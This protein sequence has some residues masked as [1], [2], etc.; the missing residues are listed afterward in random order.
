[1]KEF[2]D[3]ISDA[4][5]G[6]DDIIFE[7][8]ERN[9]FKLSFLEYK[10]GDRATYYPWEYIPKFGYHLERRKLN[11]NQLQRYLE[12]KSEINSLFPSLIKKLYYD[13]N[14]QYHILG[15]DWIIKFQ[16]GD[17]DKALSQLVKKQLITNAQK[18]RIIQGLV[19]FNSLVGLAQ[20]G[21]T[22][23][24][25][26]NTKKIRLESSSTI[27][28]KGK[29]ITFSYE[30]FLP[31]FEIKGESLDISIQ[32]FKKPTNPIHNQLNSLIKKESF[33]RDDSEDKILILYSKIKREFLDDLLK[34]KLMDHLQILFEGKFF[35]CL[36][37][38]SSSDLVNSI[39]NLRRQPINQRGI[40]WFYDE[41]QV[42]PIEFLTNEKLKDI[43]KEKEE[44]LI[45]SSLISLLCDPE[46]IFEDDTKNDFPL[47]YE[48]YEN[49]SL[50]FFLFNHNVE[51]YFRPPTFSYRQGNYPK[52][53][54]VLIDNQNKVID[55]VSQSRTVAIQLERSDI[56]LNFPFRWDS[57]YGYFSFTHK[58]SKLSNIAEAWFDWL[59]ESNLPLPTGSSA[60]IPDISV[61]L[62]L[63]EWW[64]RHEKFVIN[65]ILQDKNFIKNCKKN[66]IIID[67]KTA[68]I[69]DQ[70]NH[71]FRLARVSVTQTGQIRHKENWKYY[72]FYNDKIRTVINFVK[73]VVFDL[74]IQEKDIS[75]LE[76]EDLRNWIEINWLDELK[77]LRKYFF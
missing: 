22:F 75:L 73:A 64:S 20:N 46:A 47:A 76:I 40:T 44:D 24:V 59:V 21:H 19:E 18:K 28:I 70:K 38:I 55:I 7:I 5:N 4:H 34:S 26:D 57:H 37:T 39:D 74:I 15:N 9:R 3:D 41:I 77:E 8:K 2:Y 68:I 42:N 50:D 11:E 12:K 35:S 65:R 43:F 48:V 31:T 69:A 60:R 53:G 63:L 32:G 54:I 33:L 66:N 13:R 27:T 29:T 62:M 72:P 10:V 71:S 17:F 45:F 25:F 67:R 51:E 56:L 61:I 14:R 1:M 58:G 16:N 23:P 6:F 49:E 30:F 36:D 52:T